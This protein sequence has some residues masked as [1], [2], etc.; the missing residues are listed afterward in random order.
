[1]LP[2]PITL[3]YLAGMID[4]DGYITITRG[5]HKG[6]L[7]HAPQIG[8]AGT[9]R[10]PHDLA[11][12]IWGGT[13]SC[14]EPKIAGHRPQFQWSRTGAVAAAA[15]EAIQPYLRI[16][17]DHADLALELWGHLEDGRYSVNDPF[18]W[19]PA[20]YDPIAHREQMRAAMIELNQ[21]RRRLRSNRLLDGVEHNG[22]PRGQHADQ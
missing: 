20:D 21:S 15:I 11:A 9:R 16:K 6:K 22:F 2:D 8:I 17:C 12:S 13:V 1:M 19:L 7:Y 3:A 4:G 5:H 18:P 10:E 14:Y